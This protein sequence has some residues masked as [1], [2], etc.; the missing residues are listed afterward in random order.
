MCS[1]TEYT[2]DIVKNK[3]SFNLSKKQPCGEVYSN[4][5]GQIQPYT[6]SSKEKKVKRS[7]VR[8]EDLDM[9]NLQISIPHT[10]RLF[11]IPY[12]TYHPLA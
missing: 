12:T 11:D 5:N 10:Y 8:V 2:A 7:F 6:F 9:G 4:K 3:L 1:R